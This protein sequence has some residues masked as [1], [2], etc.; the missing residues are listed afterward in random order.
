MTMSSCISTRGASSTT[1][2]AASASCCSP[3][4]HRRDLRFRGLGIEPLDALDAALPCPRCWRTR[5]APEGA[6]L[7][8]R[9]IAGLG[10]IYVC[11][12]LHRAHLSPLRAAGTS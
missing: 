6:L 7:D 4:A 1:I 2:R 9:L 11:E 5:G 10:N 3:P 12:A 8:Q